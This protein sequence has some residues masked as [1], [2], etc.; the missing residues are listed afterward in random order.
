MPPTRGHDLKHVDMENQKQR[1]NDA[2]HTGA[3][4]ETLVFTVGILL[5]G[6]APHTGA[7]LETSISDAQSAASR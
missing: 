5:V 4:L 7:R 6:D 1:Q 3:R 2:P